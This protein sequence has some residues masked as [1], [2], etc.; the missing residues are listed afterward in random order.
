MSKNKTV[1]VCNECGSETPRW[2]GKCTSCGAW[3]TLVEV[4]VNKKSKASTNKHMSGQTSKPVL[5]NKIVSGN[6]IRFS[7]GIKELNRVLGGGI[8]PGEMALI[9]GDPGIGKSTLLLQMA[10]KLTQNGIKVFYVTGEESVQQVKM[11]AER[12]AGENEDIY[13]MAETDV[14][15][16]IQN[17][18]QINPQIVIIDSIQTLVTS[19]I[20]SAP[21]S[22]SQVRECAGRLLKIAKAKEIAVFLVGHVTK[23]GSIA[24]PRVLEHMVDCVLYFEGDNYNSF[25]ILRAV[26]NRFGST[27]EIGVFTMEG[28][29]LEEVSNPSAHLLRERESSAIGSVVTATMEGT[30]PVLVEI[31]SLLTDTNYGTPRRMTNGVD[32]NRTAMLMAVLQKRAGLYLSQQDAYVNAIG[33]IRVNEPAADLAICLSIYSSLNNNEVSPSLLAVGEVGLTGEVRAISQLSLRVAEA[34]KMGFKSI[35]VPKQSLKNLK[36]KYVIEVIAVKNINEALRKI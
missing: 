13:L 6:E 16:I 28:H 7:S 21:G 17:I 19:E 23:E 29:G 18:H 2:S 1:F 4:I 36:Q 22:V 12:L 24:G 26:K 11:R 20:G 5:L 35:I 9:G 8:V 27:N 33:G 34:E 15:L 32:Y 25:R 14:D 30:R 10:I 3:N 31:Q